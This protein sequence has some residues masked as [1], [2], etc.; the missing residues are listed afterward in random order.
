MNRMKKK[1]GGGSVGKSRVA[2]ELDQLRE[3]GLASSQSVKLN[4]S[5]SKFAVSFGAH[6]YI[7]PQKMSYTSI[8]CEHLYM[9]THTERYLFVHD[10]V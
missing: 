10:H 6:H 8:T 3:Q 2:K 7:P 1:R 4:K 9:Y 5:E